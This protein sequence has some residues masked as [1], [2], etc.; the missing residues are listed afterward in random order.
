MNYLD[1]VRLMI[2]KRSRVY[3]ILLTQFMNFVNAVFLFLLKVSFESTYQVD[4]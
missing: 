3:V 1:N 2:K 4:S